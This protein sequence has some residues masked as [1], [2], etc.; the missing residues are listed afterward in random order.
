MTTIAISIR[1]PDNFKLVTMPDGDP[2]IIGETLKTHY[3]TPEAI[4]ALLDN[5][6][7]QTLGNTIE[8]SVFTGEPTRV[9]TIEQVDL[10]ETQITISEKNFLFI[11]FWMIRDF[12]G[13]YYTAI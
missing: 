10:D 13:N 1:N 11:D 6:N 5:G 2:T 12:G 7:I 9:Y 8:E 4:N 3:N